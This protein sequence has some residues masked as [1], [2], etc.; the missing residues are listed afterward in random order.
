MLFDFAEL[1]GS[2]GPNPTMYL[3]NGRSEGL[4]NCDRRD[5]LHG[6]RRS[7][8]DCSSDSDSFR[9][10]LFW[11]PGVFSIFYF[12]ET[13]RPLAQIQLSLTITKPSG[14]WTPT[15]RYRRRPRLRNTLIWIIQA[16]S[17]EFQTWSANRR[18]VVGPE[19]GGLVPPKKVETHGKAA[20]IIKHCGIIA[21]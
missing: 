4:A 21:V 2:W 18:W 20:R 12:R 16:T 19:V 17:Q 8:K 1:L 3:F 11:W 15:S 13:P 14:L 6:L 5:F 10:I 9:F 7:Q